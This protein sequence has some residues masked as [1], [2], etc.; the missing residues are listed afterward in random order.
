[1]AERYLKVMAP[2]VEQ[3]ACTVAGGAGHQS[4]QVIVFAVQGHLETAAGERAVIDIQVGIAVFQ[5]HF[6]LVSGDA[7]W[8][9]AG[10]MEDLFR[11]V[12]AGPAEYFCT[13]LLQGQYFRRFGE[14]A[15]DLA[16][17][18]QRWQSANIIGQKASFGIIWWP[19]FWS[20]DMF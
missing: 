18:F 19:G 8:Q 11:G 7:Y 13:L 1:M 9:Y 3:A 17:Y 16:K 12:G 6:A 5:F 2:Q 4:I 10:R 14:V 15:V 20:K